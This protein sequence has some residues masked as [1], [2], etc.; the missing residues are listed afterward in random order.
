MALERHVIHLK[1]SIKGIDMERSRLPSLRNLK[2]C[3]C[4]EA[5]VIEQPYCISNIR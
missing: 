5:Y 1:R 2:S 3:A 4:A